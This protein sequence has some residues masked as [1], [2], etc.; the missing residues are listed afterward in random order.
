[1][2]IIG[3]NSQQ[4]V[5]SKTSNYSSMTEM[6]DSKNY[7]GEILWMG[8]FFFFS[9]EP[10][11]LLHIRAGPCPLGGHGLLEVKEE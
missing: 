6:S 9:T 11:I 8:F 3:F 2:R 5:G 10:Q 4:V 7:E 1:M